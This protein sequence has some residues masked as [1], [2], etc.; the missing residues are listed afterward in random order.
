MK[1]RSLQSFLQSYDYAVWVQF[2]GTVLSAL[3]MFMIRPFLV[4]YLHDRMNDAVL[5]PILI[6][7][8]Q[9]LCGMAAGIG[10]G[11]LS[12]RFG[13]KPV[14]IVSL[15]LQTISMAG[16][17]V[18]D[19]VA[20]FALASMV[21]GI[22]S[23]LFEP[24]ASA[25][26]SDI[27]KPEQRAE[28]YALLHMALNV[29]AAFGP[30]LG[31]MLFT[32]N[33][34]VVF[35]LAA[36]L[37]GMYSLLLWT[38]LPAALPQASHKTGSRKSQSSLSSFKSREM[39]IILLLTLCYLPLGFLYAQVDS[40]LPFHLKTRFV[41]YKAILALL[42]TFNGITVILL[43]LW[44]AKATARFT[45]QRMLAVSYL[46]FAVVALGYG[47]APSLLFLLTAEL[48]FSLGEMLHGPH[49]RKTISETAPVERLGYSFAVFGLGPQLSR[50]LGPLIGGILLGRWGGAVL[51]TIL[52]GSFL[53]V[54]GLQFKLLQ[55]R[56]ALQ[57]C[58]GHLPATTP[59]P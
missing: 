54:G 24:A 5:L 21:N 20:L 13:R 43:Q 23:A 33:V 40:T 19:S 46:L 9:P 6:V 27:V 8:L 25:Q 7:T 3:T 44:I 37:L 15:L 22:G 32:W 12:D 59:P 42:L 39:R 50:I 45:A 58:K 48:M 52:A 18:A 28:V 29:G 14:M 51:F 57:N 17:A 30:A 53:V 49:I 1:N 34:S 11:T 26:V 10:G 41:N 31:L 16:Y 56:A 35:W 2:T 47:F 38:R 4:L 36:L 55:M